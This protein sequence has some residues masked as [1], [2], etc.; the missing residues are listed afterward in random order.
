MDS[1]MGKLAAGGSDLQRPEQLIDAYLLERL[2]GALEELG[3]LAQKALDE[4][5]VEGAYARVKALRGLR[6]AVGALVQGQ[7]EETRPAVYLV[8][9]SFLRI[10]LRLLTKTHNEELVYV[11]G[12]EDGKHLFA[13]TR[14]VRFALSEK[15]VA[16]AAPEPASQTAALT[17]LDKRQERLLATFHSHPG[18][19]A[20]ASTP[21]S[22]DLSTQGNLERMGYPSIGAIFTRD[23]FVRFYSVKRRFRVVVSGADCEQVGEY[24]FRLTDI[25]PKPLLRRLIRHA[26]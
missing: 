2:R 25:T 12:P 21:S 20:Q 10:A 5:A 26:S 3:E 17:R 22:V 1:G 24:L 23:G 18:R 11:T 16:Y 7:S 13:L 4:K 14:L 9:A 6:R 19:G 8:S 15:S